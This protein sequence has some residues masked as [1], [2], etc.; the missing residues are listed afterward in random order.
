MRSEDQ[1]VES[2]N[3]FLLSL[4]L[5]VFYADSV[6]H[7]DHFYF[8]VGFICSSFRGCGQALG[9]HALAVLFFLSPLLR[10]HACARGTG[11][12]R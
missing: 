8:N 1:E 10:A 5:Q 2:D 7:G 11:F 12:F 4:L 6:K 9:I 3:A